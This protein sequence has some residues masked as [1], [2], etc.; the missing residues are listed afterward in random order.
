MTIVLIVTQDLKIALGIA[1][2]NNQEQACD[3]TEL[4]KGS[5][6]DHETKGW[7]SK[8]SKANISKI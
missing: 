1:L 7:F 2:V 3:A 6:N 5:L 4:G 8:I